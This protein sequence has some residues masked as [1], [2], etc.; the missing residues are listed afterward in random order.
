VIADW[1]R[2]EQQFLMAMQGPEQQSPERISNG[3]SILDLA[4]KAY[5]VDLKQS[6]VERS[7]ITPNRTFEMPSGCR[8]CLSYIQETLR[9]DLPK[10]KK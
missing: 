9:P 5:F 1:I 6:S 4:N 7:L 8:K 3:V 10:G 2:E